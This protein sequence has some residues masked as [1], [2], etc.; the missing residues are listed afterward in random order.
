MV[1]EV[2]LF[3]DDIHFGIAILC[4]DGWYRFEYAAGGASGISSSS[5]SF[6]GGSSNTTNAVTIKRKGPTGS[7]HYLGDTRKGLDDII[8]HARTHSGFH[9]TSYGVLDNNCRHFCHSMAKFMGVEQKYLEA[10]AEY[11]FSS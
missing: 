11:M 6:S 1:H 9:G 2:N 10:T 7:I 8:A 3:I 5:G 4:D